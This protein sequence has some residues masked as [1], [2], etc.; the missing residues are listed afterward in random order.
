MDSIYCLLNYQIKQNKPLANHTSL[1]ECL[2]YNVALIAH[3]PQYP[4]ECNSM[5]DTF[6]ISNPLQMLCMI[7]N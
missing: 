4:M 5:L 3:Y 6:Q 1:A 7:P 2:D